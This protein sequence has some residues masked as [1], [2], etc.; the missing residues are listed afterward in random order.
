MAPG[1]PIDAE[2]GWGGQSGWGNNHKE[3]IYRIHDVRQLSLRIHPTKSA[4][5]LITEYHY[6]HL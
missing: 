3:S 6:G 4:T 5:Y 2:A 1:A